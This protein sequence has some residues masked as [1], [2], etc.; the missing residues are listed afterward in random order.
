MKKTEQ[1]RMSSRKQP[2]KPSAPTQTLKP[3]LVLDEDVIHTA[4]AEL[5]V[6]QAHEVAKA[7]HQ[8]P[9]GKGAPLGDADRREIRGALSIVTGGQVG[10]IKFSLKDRE[11]A[12][13]HAWR[14]LK[15]YAEIISDE[16]A[17][18]AGKRLGAGGVKL[19]LELVRFVAYAE[20]LNWFRH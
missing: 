15:H 17:K 14:K 10:G 3:G 20:A 9:Q 6:Q 7:L 5:V 18:A 13:R 4:A 2:R 8:L 19:L 1:S 12:K 11:K 16:A